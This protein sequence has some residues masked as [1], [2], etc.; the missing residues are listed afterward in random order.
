MLDGCTLI[1]LVLDAPGVISK[2]KM[3][4]KH[5]LG[6]FSLQK[7]NWLTFPFYPLQVGVLNHRRVVYIV[8]IPGVSMEKEKQ[9]NTP[10]PGNSKEQK[11]DL[12]FV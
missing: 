12:V 2:K 5:C 9:A 4:N 3:K 10:P 1:L 8:L 11:C 6:R 7:G